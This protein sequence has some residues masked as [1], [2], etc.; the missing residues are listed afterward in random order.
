[1]NNDLLWQAKLAARLHDPPE[2]ALILMRTREG[3]E[4]GTVRVLLDEVFPQGLSPEVER[5]VKQADHWASA[6]DRMAFPK[7]DVDG[8][9]PAW[10]QVRFAEN[11]VLIHPLTGQAHPLQQLADDVAAAQAQALGT[12]HLRAYVDQGGDLRKTALALWRFGPELEGDLSELWKLLP[13]DSRVPDHTIHDHLDLAS[14]F[15]ACLVDPAQ[16]G[17]ALLA[18]SLGPVQD[19]IAAARSV[20]DLWAGSHL[21]SHLSWCAMRVVCEALGPEAVIFPRLRG[22]PAVDLWLVRDQGLKAEWFDHF[23]WRKRATDANPLFAAALP[24]R[25]TA[26]VPAAQ[27]EALAQAITDAVRKQARELTEEAFRRLLEAAGIEDTPSLYGY[28]QIKRQLEGFPEVHWAAVPWSLAQA[29][30]EGKIVASDQGLA[31]AMQPF[32]ASKPSGFLASPTWQALG[33]GFKLEEGLFYRP[34]P[35]A[36]YPALHELLERLLAAAKAARPFARRDEAGWRDSLTGE[37]EWIASDAAQLAL[38]PGQRQD[39][40]WTRA[41]GKFGIRAGEHLSALGLLKRLW[42]TLFVEEISRWVVNPTDNINV[43]RYVV[44]TH[45]MALAA[46][47]EKAV[48]EGKTPL[49]EVEGERVALPRKLANK[50]RGPDIEQ[51]ARLPDWLDRCAEQGDEA[52]A[53]A[54]K[55][56]EALFGSRPETYYGLLLMDG[57]SMG[58]WLSAS[59]PHTPAVLE[60]FH[61]QLRD[62]LKARFDGDPNFVRYADSRRAPNPAWHMAISQ[63]LNHFALELAP[64][65]VEREFLGKLIYAG[66]DDVL[67]MLSTRDLLPAAALLRAAYSGDEPGKQGAPDPQVCKLKRSNNGWV[68]FDGRVLRLMGEKATTSAGLVIAHHQAPLGAVMRALRDAE[69]RAKRWPGKNAWSLAILKRGGGA[70]FV[71]AP[72]GEPLQLFEELRAF[73]ASENVSRRAAYHVSEWL[74]DVPAD[75]P[76]LVAQLLGYQMKRQADGEA[77]KQEA[78]LLAQ[79]LVRLA[80]SLATRSESKS[81]QASGDESEPAQTRCEGLNPSEAKSNKNDSERPPKPLEWLSDFMMAAEFLARETRHALTSSST[82]AA[83]A[84]PVQSTTEVPA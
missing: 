55:R 56:L 63:A 7:R 5:A 39:T 46:S 32:F 82:G 15:A 64:A 11:P 44:S 6:A 37:A 65:I 47:I 81:A 31:E 13:A 60:S 59:S 70:L 51:W 28:E 76:E 43:R 33:R 74:H 26:I 57:D 30:E 73:L 50:V 52:L 62:R 8:R 77:A 23:D 38:P 19:F 48:D 84:A 3:H 83:S 54:R 1:M 53:A 25:F 45:T 10:Q 66:G 36:L 40:L 14:A 67:A 49:D 71:T 75:N 18:V 24:N 9:Y 61:P 29:E 79:R 4:G 27:V 34:Y 2:K 12:D 22:V 20:S 17:P 42:P 58:A 35:G 69:K 21:L 80:Y 68:G 41:A 78:Q 16:G 72:W